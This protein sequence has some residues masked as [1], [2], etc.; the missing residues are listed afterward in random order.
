MRVRIVF[1]LYKIAFTGGLPY[2]GN[3][4]VGVIKRGEFLYY[5]KK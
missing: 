1:L 3:E 5:I 2:R 4:P